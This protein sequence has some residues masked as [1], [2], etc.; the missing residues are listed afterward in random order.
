MNVPHVVGFLHQEDKDHVLN[1]ARKLKDTFFG[2]VGIV[3]DLT[4]VERKEEAN[5][6]AEAEE[7]NKHLTQEDKAKNLHW[8]VVGKRG[9]RRIIKGVTRDEARSSDRRS[10]QTGQGRPTTLPPATRTAPWTPRTGGPIENEEEEILETV[11]G[12]MD[13]MD[14]EDG[15]RRKRINSK[16]QRET[17][18]DSDVEP[19]SKH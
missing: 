17:R 5:M 8:L 6:L 10:W 16:R 4:A 7:K 18:I 2:E 13:T 14:T 3:P 12:H 15:T 1:N 19:A 11:E 9:E